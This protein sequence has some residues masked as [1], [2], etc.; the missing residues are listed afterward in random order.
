MGIQ[1]GIHGRVRLAAAAVG[2][3]ACWSSGF[4]AA[5]VGTAQAP[6][7]TLTLWRF[8]VA[9]AVLALLLAARHAVATCGGNRPRTP[10]DARAAPGLGNPPRGRQLAH[11]AGIGVLSQVGYVLPVYGAIALGV[12]TGAASLVD[13]VQP[14]VV[15]TLAGP[16][17]GVRVHAAQW[18]GLVAASGGVAL[19]VGADLRA[20]DA[21][22]AAYGLPAVAVASLVAATF[23]QRRLAVTSPA[24]PALTVHTAASVVV[25]VLVAVA[26]GTATPPRDPTFW[27][28]ATFTALV[29]M[30]GAYTLY[31]HLLRSVDVTVLN[32]LLFLVVP[33]TTL[34]GAAFF[35]EPFTVGTLTGLVLAGAGV[36]AVI[37]GERR[38]GAPEGV[39]DRAGE[40]AP[41]SAARG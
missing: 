32:A 30:L 33:T 9:A 28:N 25:L 23:W 6:A 26:T 37:G 31:W 35:D 22:A 16:L 39:S 2:F 40:H 19:L 18:A 36:A 24:L 11:Q 7:V 20:S 29:P 1:V 14:V 41:G 17:L 8:L 10:G 27:A 34:A 12:S 21:P 3:V 4:L 13:A 15:A 38:R 5:K